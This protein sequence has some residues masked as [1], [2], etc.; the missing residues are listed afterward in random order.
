MMTILAMTRLMIRSVA[1]RGRLIAMGLLGLIGVIIAFAVD[2]SDPGADFVPAELLSDYGL[3]LFVPVVVLVV[4]T[5]TLGTFVEDSTLVYLW[6]RPIGR[7]RIVAAALLAAG[8]VLLPL[9]LVPM[10]AMAAFVGDS[11]DVAGITLASIV[12]LVGYGSVFTLLGLLTQRAL[13]WGLLYILI[14]EGFIAGLSRGA[15]WFAVRTYT[16]S[17]LAQVGDV[18]LINNPVAT[19]TALI[20]AAG[21]AAAAFAL[22]TGRL[23]TMD[24]A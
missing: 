8:M 23:R 2:R 13:A 18:S 9:I 3:T 14:W 19:A 17:A 12:G 1:T 11:S 5:A 6:L 21:I 7:W 10:V 24:I 22:T 20:V 15:G 4:A 16:R